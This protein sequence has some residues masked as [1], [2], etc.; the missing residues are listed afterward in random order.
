MVYYTY[1]ITNSINGKMYFG[2]SSCECDPNLHNYW[3]SGALISKAIKKYGKENFTKEIYETFDNP[4]EAYA[5]EAEVV[6]EEWVLSNQSYNAITGGLGGRKASKKLKDRL[7]KQRKGKSKPFGFQSGSNNSFYGKKHT[8]EAKER[9]RKKL[10]GRDLGEQWRK[11]QGNARLGSKHSEETKR[12][13]SE[14]NKGRKYNYRDVECPYCG[15]QGR[16][17]NMSRYHFDNCKEFI[18]G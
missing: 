16:G 10:K 12:K 17:P 1:L 8:K 18:N 14:A 9:I 6:N 4:E 2:V 3:G 13:I 7:S 15:L 11:N 5:R